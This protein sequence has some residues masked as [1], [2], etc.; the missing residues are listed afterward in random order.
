MLVLALV[1]VMAPAA[2]VL[3]TFTESVTIEAGRYEV[4]V[5]SGSFDASRHTVSYAE[6]GWVEIDG[7]TRWGVGFSLPDTRLAR[8]T[9][10]F[11]GRDL[12]VPPS[13]WEHLY[14]VHI[15][16]GMFDSPADG[17]ASVTED[18]VRVR[19]TGGDGGSGYFVTFHIRRDGKHW[20]KCE[21]I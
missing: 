21:G 15:G 11:D 4:T 7:E 5:E 6:G 14:R 17:A 3:A 20:R 10:R 19:L 1:F 18:E 8:I 2:D 9:A 13:L 12:R 16:P